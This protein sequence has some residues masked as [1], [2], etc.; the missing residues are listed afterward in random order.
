[1]CGIAGILGEF[2]R[3]RGAALA[4]QMAERMRLR[5]PDGYGEYMA[6]GVAMVMRRLAIIDLVHGDQPLTSRGGRVIAFQ[7]GEIYNYRELKRD[8][9]AHGYAFT[10]TGD[11]EIL[12]H[13][14][15]RWGIDGL[16]SRIDGMFALAIYDADSRV[17]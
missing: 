15:D 9:T 5:G 3:L 4:Q 1:M 12:A 7:N 17:L 8:L 2:D 13:G 11:T 14:Y 6:D 10:T 16:L